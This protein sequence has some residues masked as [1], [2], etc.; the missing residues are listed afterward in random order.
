[1]NLPDSLPAAAFSRREH[2][3]ESTAEGRFLNVVAIDDDLNMLEFYRAALSNQPVRLETCGEARA[4]LEWVLAHDPDLVLLDL[5]MPDLDGMEILYRVRGEGLRAQVVVVTGYYSIESAVEAIREGAADYVCKPLSVEKLQSLVEQARE[6]SSHYAREEALEKELIRVFALEGL[7][8]RSPQML[9]VFDLIQ[10]FAPH[11]STALVLGET[12]TGKE[13]VARALH[14]LS[15]R[16]KM[17]FSICN[18]AALPEP[19]LESQLFGHRRGAFTGASE[20]QVGVFAA[21]RGGT[22]FLDEAGE[23]SLAAQSKLLRVVENGEIQRLGSPRPERADV[24]VIAATSHDLHRD[25]KLGKFRSDL[26]YRLDMVR[27]ALPPLRERKED[28]L[29]LGRHFLDQFNREYGKQIR[30][31]SRRAQNALVAYA[32]PGNVRELENVVGRACLLTKGKVI[33]LQELAE[34]A[35]PEPAAPCEIPTSLRE[36]ERSALERTLASTRSKVLAA[37]ILGISRAT[38]YRLID[39]HGV[40][41][42]RRNGK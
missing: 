37:R 17:T 9:E 8:G 19:L 11:F 13:L 23:L 16:R 34:V 7:V 32:W 2:R 21:A 26:L 20:D 5:T 1:M 40:N 39:R 14:N 3:K 42:D 28:V 30:G 33:D 15:P 4:G 6:S 12:G 38:L 22:V 29:L 25:A 35:K 41:P 18:C 24:L 36:L 31:F 27:I 10:R